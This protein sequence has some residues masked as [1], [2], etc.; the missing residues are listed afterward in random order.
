[1][2]ELENV[3]FLDVLDIP[4]LKINKGKITVITEP[5]GSGKST[6][7]K[8][9]NKMLSPTSGHIYFDGMNIADI[10]NITLRRNVPMLGQDVIRFK[11]NVRDNLLKGL[12]FQ[13]RDEVS[14]EILRDVLKIVELNL[15]L[16][17]DINK[18]SGGEIQRV[19]IVRLLLLN[20]DVYL[21]DEPTSALDSDT[22]NLVI[23]NFIEKSQGKTIIYVTHSE[24]IE[25]SLMLGA[26]PKMAMD[27]INKDTFDLAIMPTLNSMKNM[28]LITLPGMMTGQIL[29]GVVPTIAIKYQIAVMAIITSSVAIGVF[30]FLKFSTNKFFNE[31]KQ[32]IN[33]NK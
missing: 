24:K 12:A 25:G 27:E 30:I 13:E 1:M 7:L 18:L 14:D 21:L 8:V 31:E 10:D 6:L 2:F 32:L 33:L 9:L 23:K 22:E 3:N 19:A 20:R 15:D 29:G 17:T 4:N 28:G 16:D 26:T 11:K 5:S